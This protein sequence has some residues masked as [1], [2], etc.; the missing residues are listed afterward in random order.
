MTTTDASLATVS[1]ASGGAVKMLREGQIVEIV[2]S[3]P[4]RLNAIDA[5]TLRGLRAAV[6]Y[7]D[8]DPSVRVAVLVGEGRAFSAGGDLREVTALIQDPS[9]FGVFL[10][11]WHCVLASIEALRVPVIAAVHGFALAGGFEL[12]QVCDLVVMGDQSTIGD[13]H[14][15]YGLFPAG[16]STQRLPRQVNRRAATW[17]LLSGESLS[18]TSALSLG[19]INQVVP[20]AE[21]RTAA[22]DMARVLA[23]RSASATAA[24]KAA[25]RLGANLDVPTAIAAERQ[26]ALKHMTSADAKVGLAAFRTRTVP[27]FS[28]DLQGEK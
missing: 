28:D 5:A 15:N 11:E 8:V 20:E 4:E 12:V 18:A 19:L 17:L 6:D 13:Q 25:L 16:G 22:L 24:I 27:D 23:S 26:I 21:T 10:D 9:A 14:A 1:G 3:R 7:I 2:L